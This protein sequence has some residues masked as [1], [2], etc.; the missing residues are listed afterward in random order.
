[1]LVPALHIRDIPREMLRDAKVKAAY[2]GKTLKQW[3][4][5]L[6]ARELKVKK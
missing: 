3:V 1:M 2:L 4:L 5:D 6:I